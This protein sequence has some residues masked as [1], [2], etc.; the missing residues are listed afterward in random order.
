VVVPW[1]RRHIGC[2]V[3]CWFWLTQCYALGSERANKQGNKQAE[4][5]RCCGFMVTQVATM[6]SNLRRIAAGST[7]V[8]TQAVDW[9]SSTVAG[10]CTHT[11]KYA[12]T[13]THA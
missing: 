1:F 12:R 9:L 11:N 2:Q 6:S 5:H 8:E 3:V 10:Q 4:K 13:R 7:G